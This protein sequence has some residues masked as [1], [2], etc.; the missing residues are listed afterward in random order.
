MKKIILAL[1]VVISIVMMA[2]GCSKATAT[3]P[4]PIN[5]ATSVNTVVI[6]AGSATATPTFTVTATVTPTFT[7]TSTETPVIIPTSTPVT[8]V[9]VRVLVTDP[10]NDAA[11]GLANVAIQCG[12]YFVPETDQTLPYDNIFT[13]ASDQNITVTA[14]TDTPNSIRVRVIVS[15]VLSDL[16]DPTS[17]AFQYPLADATGN[18]IPVTYPVSYQF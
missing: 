7:S 9:F 11:Y 8:Q 15:K 12:G 5:T 2:V 1:V 16:T 18:T 4:S 10:T 13:T 6:V 14:S 3:G 17:F